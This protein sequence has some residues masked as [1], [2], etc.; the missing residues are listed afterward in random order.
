[1]LMT[2]SLI[3]GSTRG[4]RAALAGVLAAPYTF[5]QAGAVQGRPRWRCAA[6]ISA[7]RRLCC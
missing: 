5:F 7:C 3:Q 4:L 2:V 1:M 6:W